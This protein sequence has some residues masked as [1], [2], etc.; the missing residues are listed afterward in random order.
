MRTVYEDRLRRLL[1]LPNQIIDRAPIAH[2]YWILV[3]PAN[4]IG[5]KDRKATSKANEAI[6][7]LYVSY[8][9]SEPSHTRVKDRKVIHCKVS[10]ENF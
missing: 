8:I 7:K 3:E 6:C 10:I 4:Q 2:R 1:R 9:Q 5:T